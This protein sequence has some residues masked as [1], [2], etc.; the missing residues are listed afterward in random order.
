MSSP[1]QKMFKNIRAYFLQFAAFTEEEWQLAKKRILILHVKKG[2]FLLK[3]GQVCRIVSFI[4]KGIVRMVYSSNGKSVTTGFAQEGEYISD[5]GSFL[6][7]QPAT[8]AIE[9]LEDCELLTLNYED[10]HFLY[11]QNIVYSEMGRKIAEKLFLDALQ[12]NSSI[13]G[14]RPEHRYQELVKSNSPLLQRVPQFILASYLRISPEHLSRI[15]KKM[16]RDL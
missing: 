3:Q 13:L 14:E 4:E 2:N 6:L 11:R 9:A 10:L 12:I 7:Q 8:Y 16:L 15:R 5:Y 1:E